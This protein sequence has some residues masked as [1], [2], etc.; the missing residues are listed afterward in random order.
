MLVAR[1]STV[2][3]FRQKFVDMGRDYFSDEAYCILFDFLEE[4][5]ETNNQ[6]VE[7]DVIAMCC[8]FT[9]YCD[10]TELADAYSLAFTEEQ[11]EHVEECRDEILQYFTDNTHVMELNNGGFIISEF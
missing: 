4:T 6:H 8:E 2:G 5:S 9:E 1:I 3:Q 11:L 10:L 7:L